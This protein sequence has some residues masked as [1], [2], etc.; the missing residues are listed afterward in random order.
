MSPKIGLQTKIKKC[1]SKTGLEMSKEPER[2]TVS[3]RLYYLKEFAESGLNMDRFEKINGLGKS[4]IARWIRMYGDPSK[5]KPTIM[6]P[7]RDENRNKSANELLLEERVRELELSLKHEKL[8]SHAYK[9]MIEVAEEELG[10]EISKKVG[11][12][13]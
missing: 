12:K 4:A 13:Q 9:T 10:I 7:P 2:Y 5:I 1:K 3:Q 11:A 8:R 6:K